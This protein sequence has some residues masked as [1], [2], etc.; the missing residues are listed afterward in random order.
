MP[1]LFDP[2]ELGGFSAKNRIFMSPLTRARAGRDAVPTAIMAKYYAQRAEAGLIITEATGISREG[3]GWPYAPGIWSDEQVE[4]WKPITKAVHDRGGRIVCQLWHMGR[5]VHS[6]V[7][8]LQPVAPS[9]TT[10]PGQSHTYDGK[11]PYEEARALRLDEIP[12]IL[13]EYE[14]ASQ[15]AIKAGF[16]GIQLHAANGY[17]IDEFLKDGTNHRTDEYG[18]SPEN[19]I[20]LL[21]QVTERII[22]TIGGER[23]GVRLS[24][25]GDTQGCLDS[26]PETVFVPAA[27]ELER[28]GVAWLELRE[29]GPNGT[30][31]KTDQPPVSPQ[32]RKVFRRP[33]VLNQDYTFESAQDAVRE[34]RADAIAFGRKFISNPDLPTRFAQGLPLQADDMA[35]WYSRGEHGYTDYSFAE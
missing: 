30:F 17:L 19:R 23:T 13:A 27:A 35:T 28:L 9:P 15:N 7:T 1:D 14:R 25:N 33:L 18:G 6:S 16:D 2:I 24:P 3:L 4:A 31:G 34:G 12:R 21:S 26:A 32:I 29:P 20:R 10:A 5:M 11:Q 22:S 8:G